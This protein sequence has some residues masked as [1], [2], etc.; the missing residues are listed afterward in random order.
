LGTLR[1][2]PSGTGANTA[3]WQSTGLTPGW[4]NI[5]VTWLEASDRATNAP[6]TVYDGVNARG[7]YQVNQQNAPSGQVYQGRPWQ[8]LAI[9]PINS[10]NAK[11][12]LSDQADG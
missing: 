8:S 2:H 10:T 3:A 4:Y 11:I 7:T 9:V 6:Y 12:V 1:W 5:Q